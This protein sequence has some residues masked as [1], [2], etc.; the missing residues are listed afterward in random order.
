MAGAEARPASDG[1]A[2]Q[3]RGEILEAAETLLAAHG[4]DALRLR[5]VSK[6]AGVSIG[7]IQHYFGTRDELLLETMRVASERRA[8]QWSQ[9]AEGASSADVKLRSLIE[10]AVGDHHRCVIWIEMC[11]AATR[12]P[13]LLPDVR[14]TQDAW[15]RA[16]TDVLSDGTRD[17]SFSTSLSP[18]D[19]AELLIRIIDGFILDAAVDT[20]GTA[21]EGRRLRLL[22]KAADGILR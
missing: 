4:Y 1:L 7:L 6:A 20:E 3:R 21:A 16:I 5:D 2:E 14:R 19:T 13:E 22:K 15:H 12:H 8:R 9:A 10:G 11:A 18:D 17:G